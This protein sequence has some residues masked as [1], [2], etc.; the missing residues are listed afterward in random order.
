LPL[1]LVSAVSLLAPP[2]LAAQTQFPCEAHVFD[3]PDI[4]VAP[5]IPALP[6]IPVAVPAVPTIPA[7][8]VAT[9]TVPYIPVI[10]AATFIVPIIP[11]IPLH[12]A[13]APAAAFPLPLP[14][15]WYHYKLGFQPYTGLRFVESSR[16]ARLRA[17]QARF[18]VLASAFSG[19]DVNALWLPDDIFAEAEIEQSLWDFDVATSTEI[20]RPDE[21]SAR[22]T[23]IPVSLLVS[24][25]FQFRSLQSL[26]PVLSAGA[27]VLSQTLEERSENGLE[28]QREFLPLFKA[29]IGFEW[30]P[31]D[32][33]RFYFRYDYSI[34]P[35]ESSLTPGSIPGRE[36]SV[37][38]GIEWRF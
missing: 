9:F 36:H 3:I 37:K 25:A 1:C 31:T 19:V 30:Q 4:S 35:W 21:M 14:I 12:S 20:L 17:R 32:Q 5:A 22:A 16:A 28:S 27:G 2:R 8:P 34:M 10:P 7:I 23:R 6:A 11:A 33:F 15:P 13:A 18:Q 29:G 38:A 24:R 26:R